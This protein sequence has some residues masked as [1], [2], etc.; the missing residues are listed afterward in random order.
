MI[1]V[2]SGCVLD[3]YP[4]WQLLAIAH[5]GFTAIDLFVKG[6]DTTTIGHMNINDLI[7][8]A[9]KFGLDAVLYSYLQSYKHPDDPD[10]EEFFDNV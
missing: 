2:H 7:E 5:A 4:D 1:S 3:E 8:R 6:P 10:A 9:S